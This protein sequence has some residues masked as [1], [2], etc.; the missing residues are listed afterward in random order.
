MKHLFK[1]FLGIALIAFIS[2]S[3]MLAGG[4]KPK[5]IWSKEFKGERGMQLSE[6]VSKD[7]N[8]FY[9]LHKTLAAFKKYKLTLK[10]F[11]YNLDEK[12]SEEFDLD[13]GGKERIFE[14]MIDFGGELRCFTSFLNKKDKKYYLFVETVNRATLKSKRDIQKVAEVTYAGRGKRKSDIDY[15]TYQFIPSRD[16]SNLLIFSNLPNRANNNERF[17]CNVLNDDLKVLWYNEIEIPYEDELFSI[18]QTS[19]SSSGDV[20]VLG[21]LYKDKVKN[22]RR[23][24]VN[25]KYQIVGYKKFGKEKV[26]YDINLPEK[27]ITDMNIAVDDNN[28][29]ICTG[30]YGNESMYTVNGTYFMKIDGKTKK[31]LTANSKEFETDFLLQNLSEK[32]EKKA[33]KKIAKGKEDKLSVREYDIDELIINKDG[34]VNMIGEQFRVYTTVV[35]TTNSNGQTTTRTVTH[36]IF[37]EIIVVNFSSSGNINWYKRIPKYQHTTDDRGRYSSYALM[38]QEDKLHFFYNDHVENINIDDDKGKKYSWTKRKKKT[39]VMMTT[40]DANGNMSRTPITNVKEADMLLRPIVCE[41]ISNDQFVFYGEKGA[42]K[43]KFAMITPR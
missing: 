37:N 12:A 26:I 27:F 41:Q 24:K 39:V 5:Q 19:V 3:F 16:S 20:Y 7:K 35:T 42:K 11:S 4:K 28:D 15:T 43:Y 33:K 30:F 38:K 34:S 25:F 10:R 36:Y 29:I 31:V 8:G 2:L 21:K 9:T 40:I 17:A 1:P 18:K 32:G 13:Y 23:N 22:V 6:I 14:N